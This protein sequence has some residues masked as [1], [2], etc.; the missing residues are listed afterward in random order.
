MRRSVRCRWC[1][2]TGHNLR[3]CDG[4]KKY[5]EENPNSSWAFRESRLREA[6]KNRKCSY[7]DN[8]GHNKKTCVSKIEHTVELKKLNKAFRKFW[9]RELCDNGIGV[10]ALISCNNP[11]NTWNPEE[12]VYTRVEHPLMFVESILW[13][14]ISITE[15]NSNY[16]IKAVYT[17]I[18]DHYS[19][20]N[21]QEYIGINEVNG[22][23]YDKKTVVSPVQPYHESLEKWYGEDCE[24]VKE[25]IEDNN[26]RKVGEL[27]KFMKG[28]PENS[29]SSYTY[30]S[31][32][33]IKKYLDE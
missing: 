8:V 27:I 12:K 30:Y 14:K 3:G 21:K 18:Y 15:W 26:A 1:S 20:K 13:D 29:Y 22:T 4:Y 23:S 19:N 24:I 2:Q 6:A 9:Y 31:P 5:I 25:F 7:C 16:K 32:P 10:G 11:S 33:D 28:T 17:N